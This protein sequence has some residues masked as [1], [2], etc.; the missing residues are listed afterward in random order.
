[1]LIQGDLFNTWIDVIE[2]QVALCC[3]TDFKGKK[4]SKWQQQI[5]NI[6]RHKHP[7]GHGERNRSWATL[8][9]SGW[10]TETL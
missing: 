6:L 5:N 1:M 2:K 4:L 3:N 9:S 8:T 7:A 10:K